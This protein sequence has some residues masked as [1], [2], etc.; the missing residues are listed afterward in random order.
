MPCSSTRQEFTL[1]FAEDAADLKL[2]DSIVSRVGDEK[3]CLLKG[4]ITDE[5]EGPVEGA[6]IKVWETDDTDIMTHGMRI[7][8]SLL[9][10]DD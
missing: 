10:V 4:R 9:I 5:K 7:E 1:L 2:G 8:R 3:R 6:V